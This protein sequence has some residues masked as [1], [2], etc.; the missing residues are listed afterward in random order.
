MKILIGTPIHITKDYAMERWLENVSKLDYPTDLLLVDNSPGTGYEKKVKGCC[1]KYGIKNYQIEHLELP[2]EQN[3]FERVARSRE[4][5]RQYILSHYYDAWF[6]WECDQLIPNN[7]LSELIKMME[8]GNF[9]IASHNTQV[10][11]NPDQILDELFGTT[12]IKREVLK[13]HSFILEFG[14][15]P[16]M[17][18]AWEPSEKWFRK[19]VLKDGG[20]TIEADGVLKP[21]YHLNE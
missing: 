19:Q 2:L 16:E 12:L 9:M 3:V 17:P 11:E 10:R 4:V 1:V 7:S 20:S 8:S 21:V 14:T 15:D 18:D 5:I 6:S 13:K